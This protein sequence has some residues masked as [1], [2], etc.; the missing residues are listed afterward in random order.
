MTI[1][2]PI[3]GSVRETGYGVT[4][5]Y[6]NH[7][8]IHSTDTIRTALSFVPSHNRDV[9]KDMGM[10]IQSELGDAGF[11][12]W[13]EWSSQDA[14]YNLRA[15]K[16]V[17]KSFKPGGGI[18][19]G[20][21]FFEAQ[22]HGFQFD[23]A[24]QRHA[25]DPAALAERQRQHQE[26]EAARLNRADQAAKQSAII[27]D[28]NKPITINAY[29]EKKQIAPQPGRMQF[30]HALECKGWFWTTDDNGDLVELTGKLLLLPLY[31]IGG[32]LRGLQAID[33]QGRK[34]LIKG[35]GKQGLFIPLTGGKVP[36]DYTGKIIISEGF[37]TSAT[38]RQATNAPAIAA[39]DAGNLLHVAKAWREKCP[40]VEIIIGGDLDK[41]GTGQKKANEAALAVGGKVA[42][43]PF[44]DDE[45]AVDHPPSD[46]N[47]YA[48]LHD[49]EAIKQAITSAAAP[50]AIDHHQGSSDAPGGDPDAWPEPQPMIVKVAP[51]TYP[52]DAL[53]G[54]IRA[55]VRE[56]AEFVKSPLPMLASSA[57]A[58]LSLAIQAHADVKRAEKLH[59]PVG[60]FLLTIADSGE[61]KSTCDG[62][63][64]RAIRD[65]EEAQAEAAKPIIRNHKADLE[66]WE[67]K[68][69]GI[70][71]KI[72]Q[73]AK[74]NKPTAALES[75]LRDLEHDKPE[76][77]RIPRL[78]FGDSTPE[79]TAFDLAKKWPSGGVV[80]AEA[81]IVFGAHGMGKDSVMR[82]LALLNVLWDGGSLD[83]G[84]RTTESFTVRGA[85][86]TMAL[87]VQ[88]PT[89][90][91]F[92]TRSG[93]LARG[94]GFLARFLVA[95][96]ESTQGFRP[97]TEAP[98]NW[99]HLAIFNKRIAAI[100]EQ[101][102]PI[103]E[104]GALTPPM[105]SLTPDAK[106]AWI[107]YHDAIESELASDGELHDVRDV[108][109]KSADNAV[110]LAALFQVF[111]GGG[112]IGLDCFESASRIAAWHLNEARRFFGELAL[113]QELAD[114]ARL[115]SWL[116][117]Y[118]KRERT[119]LVPTREAQRLGPI[120]DKERLTTALRELEE[121]DRVR[122][123]QEGRRKTIKVNP[124]LVGVAA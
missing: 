66:A 113:P 50:A 40:H 76:Q 96:P 122:M 71:D 104:D 36:A 119:H 85:R 21:L 114:A 54:T 7:S 107:E 92:F 57:L 103:D 112:A 49:P 121:H 44:T 117:E 91:E 9:W 39:I 95:W 105:L 37:A 68:R 115:D 24:S 52:E 34:S 72:R 84:R 35:L 53:P 73:L 25:P 15:A 62:F 48:A 94:T 8:L 60:L 64:T 120:R 10:A 82:N 81:G 41:S 38:I 17:W 108:A 51:E 75:D 63:F 43:P 109:S 45:L 26:A 102:A 13:D 47:D 4:S 86:L 23:G 111:Q 33:E 69:G 32:E 61:R 1:K 93:A 28:K 97:F 87:Q 12:L 89:L 58:A 116:I 29:C 80:S 2:N 77:P 30:A 74:E 123:T 55:A 42:L 110:R 124:A 19:V 79:S 18:G 98:E 11:D 27:W 46:W 99:P 65:Y 5:E 3:P 67:A 106:A 90:R 22:Q 16:T 83:I 78:L 20:T 59:G 70:K 31:N 100:L 14:T 118:C 101:P 6:R 88:E 56:V